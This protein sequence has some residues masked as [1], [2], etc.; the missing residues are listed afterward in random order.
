MDL[1]LASS[2]NNSLTPLRHPA[3]LIV[4]P[5]PFFSNSLPSRL[6]SG[7]PNVVFDVS[8]SR[9]RG[10]SMLHGGGTMP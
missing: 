3:V 5:D 7:L 10:L 9:D 2:L 1:R 6:R 4:D 8:E